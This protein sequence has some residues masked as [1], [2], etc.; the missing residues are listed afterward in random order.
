MNLFTAYGNVYSSSGGGG[1]NRS[2]ALRSFAGVW[3]EGEGS[4]RLMRRVS[5]FVRVRL[6]I[7]RMK[8]I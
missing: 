8:T 5:E 6:V 3:E 1:V 7:L 4:L 2:R